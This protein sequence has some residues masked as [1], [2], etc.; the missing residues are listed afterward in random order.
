MISPY[1]SGIEEPL[2]E[3]L[4]SMNIP[5]T[6]ENYI[7]HSWPGDDMPEEWTNEHE[8]MLPRELQD[9]SVFEERERR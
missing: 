7:S 1:P 2:I 6:R 5:V 3:W 4:E 9:W 8:A